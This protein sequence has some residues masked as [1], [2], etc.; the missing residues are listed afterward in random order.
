M[1]DKTLD[2]LILPMYNGARVTHE[3][4]LEDEYIQIY[5]GEF[6]TENKTQFVISPW[7]MCDDRFGIL[8]DL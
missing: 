4:W 6:I 8:E 7:M 2:E 3:D 5:N 1:F